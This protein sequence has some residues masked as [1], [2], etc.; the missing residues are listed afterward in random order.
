MKRGK[1]WVWFLTLFIVC[2]L[3]FFVLPP[4]FI[5]TDMV[6]KERQQSRQTLEVDEIYLYHGNQVQKL[7][8]GSGDY[9]KLVAEVENLINDFDNDMSMI[10]G[11]TSF[12]GYG[13]ALPKTAKDYYIEINFAEPITLYY[14]KF[15]YSGMQSVLIEVEERC[16]FY[17]FKEVRTK[18]SQSFTGFMTKEKKF[19][20]KF[21]FV[22][23][24]FEE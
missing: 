12:I 7:A 15:Q 20:K 2:V 16:Y 11:C 17:P 24:H 18:N 22:K 5:Q 3:G 14:D 10:D 21:D 1:F 9:E 8:K 19:S 23:A 6:E 4:L 13:E